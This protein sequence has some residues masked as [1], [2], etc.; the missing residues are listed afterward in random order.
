MILSS[1]ILD[2][3]SK[4]EENQSKKTTFTKNKPSFKTTNLEKIFNDLID[5]YID[6]KVG[7]S[8]TFLSK[9]LCRNL[10]ENLRTAYAQKQMIPAGTGNE[11]SII[12]NKLN[13]SDVI[14]WLD[15]KHNNR[16]ENSFFDLIDL[17]I[18]HL[19]STCFTGI[20]GYEFHYAMYEK[21]SFYKRHLDQFRNDDSRQYSV[22]FYLNEDWLAAD[23][24]E[25]CV[26]FD[27]HVQMISPEMGTT[28]FFKSSE[29]EHEVMPTNKARL[30][31]VGWLKTGMR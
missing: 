13:R 23:G 7:I 12:H 11:S 9:A 20:S 29:L 22:I 8:K 2:R 17:F 16:Y 4:R 24:G 27:N 18:I 28:V 10:A 15:R 21:G 3:C 1:P 26:Y 5:G 25:L 14:L 30:S 31:I 6:T 19:N